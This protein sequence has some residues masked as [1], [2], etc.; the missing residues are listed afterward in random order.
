M[1][2]GPLH[3]P[4]SIKLGGTLAPQLAS[5]QQLALPVA[6]PIH[7]QHSLPQSQAVGFSLMLTG[8]PLKGAA[9]AV[10]RAGM[11]LLAEPYLLGVHLLLALGQAAVCRAPGA[12]HGAVACRRG[13]WLQSAHRQQRGAQGWASRVAAGQPVQGHL[14]G[15]P[16]THPKA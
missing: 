16:C 7:R 9:H 6:A 11:K 2:G 14:P 1:P 3:Q 15:L 10:S 4:A 8:V 5:S 12:A 13:S